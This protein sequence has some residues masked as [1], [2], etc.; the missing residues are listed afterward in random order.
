MIVEK[1]TRNWHEE[2]NGVACYIQRIIIANKKR[3][4]YNYPRRYLCAGTDVET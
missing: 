3:T 4:S 2:R 1:K